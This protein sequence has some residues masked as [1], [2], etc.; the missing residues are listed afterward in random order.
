MK[1]S[2]SS[3]NQSLYTS[4]ICKKHRS[5]WTEQHLMFYLA[6]W[7]IYL[8]VPQTIKHVASDMSPAVMQWI[9]TICKSHISSC[10]A[11]GCRASWRSMPLAGPLI[12]LPQS[13]KHNVRNALNSHSPIKEVCIGISKSDLEVIRSQIILSAGL[14]NLELT[15]WRNEVQNPTPAHT[16][17]H[18]IATMMLL[19][20]NLKTSIME[21]T[22]HITPVYQCLVF[23]PAWLASLYYF[24][25]CK[26]K[27]FWSVILNLTA[28]SHTVQITVR[29]HTNISLQSTPSQLTHTWSKH[30]GLSQRQLHPSSAITM[31][32]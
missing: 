30:N 29:R 4:T 5:S 28:L 24:K 32:R 10:A 12:C 7:L 9:A 23:L 20:S 25:T 8:Q 16:I 6:F 21:Y 11:L 1:V 13:T 3:V 15:A 14:F 26:N 27:C 31:R 19:H 2:K 22:R 17:C 18:R